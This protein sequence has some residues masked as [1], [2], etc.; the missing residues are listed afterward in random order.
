MVVLFYRRSVG[1]EIG[2][3]CC[4]EV[5]TGGR[6]HMVPLTLGSV[7]GMVPLTLGS[8]GGHGPSYLRKCGGAW[9]PLP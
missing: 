9:S 3:A 4:S 2:V 6:G 7:G 8:V 5:G 1:I